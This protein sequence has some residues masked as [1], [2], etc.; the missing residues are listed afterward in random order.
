MYVDATPGGPAV[1]HDQQGL[2][3]AAAAGDGQWNCAVQHVS[4]EQANVHASL[5][6]GGSGEDD[7]WNSGVVQQEYLAQ[8]LPEHGADVIDSEENAAEGGDGT[9]DGPLADTSGGAG[10]V[11]FGGFFSLQ[12][13]CSVASAP[14]RKYLPK[15]SRIVDR[16]P[17][18]SWVTPGPCSMAFL[19]DNMSTTGGTRAWCGRRISSWG[20][21]SKWRYL[22]MEIWT[23][24]STVR[25]LERR[26]S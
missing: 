16:G 21:A 11:G 9:G 22:S 17:W 24:F 8:D 10:G 14:L 15:F 7:S 26:T 13:V 5:G 2:D 12:L 1:Y 23:S 6:D 20:M 19:L 18:F 3:G 4:A 25:C